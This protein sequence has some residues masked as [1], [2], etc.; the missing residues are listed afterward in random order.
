MSE[1][2]FIISEDQ[3]D[4]GYNAKAQWPNGNRSIFTQGDDREDLLRNIRDAI[5]CSFDDGEEQPDLIRLQFVH[6]EVIA[7]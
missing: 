2:T 7:R 6:D 4:G 1:I 5:D 3:T